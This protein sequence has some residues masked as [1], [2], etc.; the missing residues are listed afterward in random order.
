MMKTIL[1]IMTSL[2]ANAALNVP[3]GLAVHSPDNGAVIATL[4]VDTVA[5]VAKK[6]NAARGAQ[7]SWA[8]RSRKE[9]ETL[10]LAFSAA[11]K[12]VRDEVAAVL[13]LESGKTLKEAAGEVESAAEQ[14]PKTIRDATLPELNGML[15]MKERPPV[16]VVGLIT[17]FNFPIAV[18]H[19]T[20]APAF[21]AGNAVVWK[22]SE[23]TPLTALAVKAIF[24]RVPGT[25][26][27]LLQVLIGG[28]AAGEALVAD[29]AVDMISATGSVGMGLGIKKTLAKKKNN[30]IPPILELGG[31]NG[32][33]ISNQLSK[34][35]LE[36]SLKAIMHSF[37]GTTGQRC[38]NTR[39]VFIHRDVYDE[40]VAIA[41]QL[42]EAFMN[43][44]IT[45]EG[46]DIGNAYGFAALIDADGFTRFERAKQQV[47]ADG[48]TIL[49]GKRRYADR[50]P[51]AFYVEPVLALLPTQTAI[52][53][54]ETFAP[55]LYLVP[56]TG[57]VAT[58][59]AMVNA[60][61]NAGLV[62]GIYT[63]NQ[64]EADQF[65]ATVDAGHA[66]IN[67]PKGT[68]TPAFG[69]G[70]GGNKHS[71]CGEI[72]NSADPLAPFVRQDRFTR[73]AQNKDVA[74]S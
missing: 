26:K 11:L 68:G 33:I 38:T 41:R 71:G 22:P 13:H 4:A 37:L 39:R 15:R 61:E 19:W 52:M 55:L 47:A 70:F 45:S 57:D 73:V 27:D 66:L 8:T 43:S 21:L 67:A 51:G 62:A 9:K 12:A 50:S 23:K 20:M 40:A 74:M 1:E 7:A 6:I 28:R 48:G 18:A 56:Y 16:G 3:E 60:P 63:Q 69:M 36:W 2:G 54:E 14:M 35:H 5:T 49:F 46:I 65:A 44:V 64:R 34:A 53:H 29:E 17:S 58:A 72:L 32:V 10:L 24:D 42:I 31:N 30:G 59:V 25:P